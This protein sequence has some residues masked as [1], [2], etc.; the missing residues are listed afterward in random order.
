MGIVQSLAQ[1]F[2][3]EFIKSHHANMQLL[4]DREGSSSST[5]T[6]STTSVSAVGCSPHRWVSCRSF[7]ARRMVE[8]DDEMTQKR[9]DRSPIQ[10]AF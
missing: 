2:K 7:P 9:K 10:D 3:E 1:V 6:V 4:K 8:D 5:V